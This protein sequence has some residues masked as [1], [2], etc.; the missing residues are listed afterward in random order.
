VGRLKAVKVRAV[1]WEP[2]LALGVDLGA[3][4]TQ[5]V[6]GGYEFG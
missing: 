4:Y 3:M 6:E 2:V 5:R 1:V